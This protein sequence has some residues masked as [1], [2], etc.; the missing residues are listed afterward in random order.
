MNNTA[1]TGNTANTS[2][3][4][5]FIA[6]TIINARNRFMNTD[7]SSRPFGETPISMPTAF[8]YAH[9][10]ARSSKTSDTG[11]MISNVRAG[12]ALESV[13][14][15]L[16]IPGTNDEWGYVVSLSKGE[17]EHFCQYAKMIADIRYRDLPVYEVDAIKTAI[18][19]NLM[20]VRG[21]KNKL[22]ADEPISEPIS[23]SICVT[24][25]I[26]AA[27]KLLSFVT[28]NQN[29]DI[30]EKVVPVSGFEI[31]IEMLETAS[32]SSEKK[33]ALNGLVEIIGCTTEQLKQAIKS[34]KGLTTDEKERADNIR[35]VILK[36]A[37]TIA[38]VKVA[39]DLDEY[40]SASGYELLGQ[41]R[42]IPS[43]GI[44]SGTHEAS[45]IEAIDTL[46]GTE[47][48]GIISKFICEPSEANA[49]KVSK[50]LGMLNEALTEVEKLQKIERPSE[51]ILK[52][53]IK[54]AVELHGHNKAI[55]NALAL[56]A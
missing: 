46:R 42:S 26:V 34:K 16:Q 44:V 50:Q 27:R 56:S 13:F 8:S 23:T 1:T 32:D 49:R 6:T 15:T 7:V 10:R 39:E 20:A 53:T 9:S 55:H 18:I 17:F 24:P 52:L 28:D 35:D 19:S 11:N 51:R 37:K 33:N 41:L 47:D 36:H 12:W 4:A 25:D 38:L 21:E 3:N 14:K 30:I 2:A 45:L 40:M 22:V 43:P 29:A 48:E 31:T 5:G 54:G